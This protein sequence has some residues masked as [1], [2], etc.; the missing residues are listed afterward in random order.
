MKND[1]VKVDGSSEVAV[2]QK[3]MT[4][5]G[6]EEVPTNIIPVPFYKLVQP[7][8]TNIS[9]TDGNDAPVGSIF[10]KDAGTATSNL[11]F[12]LL[13]AKRLSREITNEQGEIVK[14]ISMGVLGINLET[15]SPFILNVPVSSFSNFGVLMKQLKDKK[16]TRAWEYAITVSSQKVEK[17]KNTGKGMQTVKYY[18]LNFQVNEK[19]EEEALALVSDAYE[20]FAGVLDRTVVEEEPKKEESSTPF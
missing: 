16:V 7:G 1:V 14:T 10:M 20:E 5:Q 13:R 17:Q 2:V 8:S 3:T 18:V 12:A 9:L 4:I 19:L 11:Q 6:L 15:F